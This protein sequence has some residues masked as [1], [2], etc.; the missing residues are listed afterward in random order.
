MTVLS[1]LIAPESL[2]SRLRLGQRLTI[3]LAATIA[4][5]ACGGGGETPTENPPGQTTKKG[6]LSISISGV[7]QGS[8]ASVVVSG[9]GGY[10]RTLG[11]T[12]LLPEL[13]PGNYAV[14]AAAVTAMG[15]T[16]SP[17]APAQTVTVSAGGA[18]AN[19]WVGYG[20]TTGAVSIN[21]TGLPPAAPGAV[22][23]EGPDGF[24]RTVTSSETVTNLPTGSYALRVEHVVA[25]DDEYD[26]EQP[27]LSVAVSA[28]LNPVPVPVN[29]ALK[30]GRLAVVVTGLP[31]GT[32]AA[33]AVSGPNGYSRT[34]SGNQTLNG[35]TPGAYTIS[36]QSVTN[37]QSTYAPAPATQ[38]LTVAPSS[39]PVQA[40]VAYAQLGGNLTLTVLGLPQ[41]TPAAITVTGP[42]GY[43][44][45]VTSTTTL[46]GL[47]AGSYEILAANAVAGNHVYAPSPAS[48]TLTIAPGTPVATNVTYAIASGALS[49]LVS[50]LPQG[51]NANVAITGPGGFSQQLTSTQA[52]V[53]LTP[54]TY[55]VA[56]SPVQSGGITYAPATPTVKSISVPAST[57]AVTTSVNYVGTSSTGLT[58]T[59]NG[60][61]GGVNASVTVAGPG[62]YSQILHGTQTLT[63]LTPGTYSVAAA[64]VDHGGTTY[65]PA[66]G[67]QSSTVTSGQTTS[68]TVSYSAGA[69]PGL[70]IQIDGMYITQSIQTYTGTVPLIASRDGF[71]RVF[72]K[73]SETNTAQPAVRVRFY[74]GASLL[75]TLTI[76]APSASV[77]LSISEGTLGAS[78]N[79]AVPASL[80]QPGVSV[81]A[82]VDPTNS[83]TEVDEGDNTFPTNGTPLALAVQSVPTWNVRLVPVTQSANS[84]TG[85][86][87]TGN[88]D[89]FLAD[90]RRMFPLGDINADVRSP[91]TTSA[92]ALV[93]DES[94]GSWSQI[95][96][97]LNSLRAAE[98]GSSRYYYGV[99]KT[100]YSSGVAGIGYVPGRTS[101]G[102]DRLP[103]GA[104]VMAHEI[105]HNF[106]RSHAPCGG[107]AGPDPGYPYPGGLIG[108]YGFDVAAGVLK[109][110]FSVRDL[111]GYCSNVWISDYNYVAIM[112]Y[113]SSTPFVTSTH[114][115]RTNVQGARRALLLWGRIHRG[116]LHL[117]PA[118][119][120]DAPATYPDR[121]GPHRLEA[122]GPRGER[123]LSLSFEGERPADSSDPR[124]RH[125]A[126]VIPMDDLGSTPLARLR[127]SALGRTVELAAAAPLRPDGH[128]DAPRASNAGAGRV[129]VSWTDPGVRGVLVRDARTGEILSFARSGLAELRMSARDVELIVSDGVRSERRRVTV[130]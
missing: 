94:N 52:L 122:L 20:V 117:E 125:F 127:F 13:S 65:I 38:T 50:G 10:S 105:G 53:G 106:G 90:I 115:A 68:A 58:V 85:D 128:T 28:S 112:N 51:V 121:R 36:A 92:P 48:R 49:V 18:V 129:R 71:L 40:S 43:S 11:S 5:A 23:L 109:S 99:V 30:S 79:V 4:L 107:P 87:T 34:I 76:N 46:T 78:W 37:G 66:P 22:T 60:L 44:A 81:L 114:A 3:F 97:E 93:A 16:F 101:L 116:Q 124:D 69:P 14:T 96:S 108:V 63:G 24:R 72:V 21:I 113:R 70:N 88:K 42:N 15:H 35:L 41:A 126:F 80:L 1:R 104:E 83:V 47:L 95:L 45:N 39:T 8:A 120:I 111:M 27:S 100:T 55:T 7:P 26:P 9:P 118:Y 19:V 31:N 29:Y 91:Y 75:N 61:P 64:N 123:L 54:G 2:A 98:V 73:A 130:R 12:E 110:P 67:S 119:E 74:S 57:S 86:V 89:A 62:G 25:G 32:H 56:A 102:W 17:D 82:D 6:S 84:L 33:I 77:P 59:V 103:S